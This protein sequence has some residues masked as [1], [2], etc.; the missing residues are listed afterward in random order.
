V[1]LSKPR[2]QALRYLDEAS[3]ANCALRLVTPVVPQ[4]TLDALV[5]GGLVNVEEPGFPPCPVVAVTDRGRRALAHAV[6]RR[7]DLPALVT[8]VRK[9]LQQVMSP[10]HAGRL[11][12]CVT[13]AELEWR[14]AAAAALSALPEMLRAAGV[15]PPFQAWA[16]S[17]GCVVVAG[18]WSPQPLAVMHPRFVQ[19]RDLYGWLVANV[20]PKHLGRL[21]LVTPAR[22]RYFLTHDGDD[23]VEVKPAGD[24][25]AEERRLVDSAPC[26]GWVTG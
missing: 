11:V 18:N 7:T 21:T 20:Y 19:T 3:L 8:R 10:T 4:G 1:K 12:G 16:S 13:E 6:R 26:R 14:E 17:H 24:V 23:V 2:I 15:A 5:R 9:R 22:W 25:R